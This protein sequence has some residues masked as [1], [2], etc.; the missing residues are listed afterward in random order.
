M[1]FSAEGYASMWS[2]RVQESPSKQGLRAVSTDVTRLETP[3]TALLA[4]KSGLTHPQLYRK[5]ESL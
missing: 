4:V 2:Y 3:N 1:F 5:G